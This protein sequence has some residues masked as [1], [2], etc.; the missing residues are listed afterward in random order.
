MN[1]LLHI[2]V[3]YYIYNN[4]LKVL[5]IFEQMDEYLLYYNEY[6][7][8]YGKNN[9][10][11]LMQVGSFF[12]I[13][14]Y[15]ENLEYLDTVANVLGIRRTRK[16]GGNSSNGGNNND[17]Y[18]SSDSDSYDDDDSSSD[19]EKPITTINKGKK[20][21]ATK[22]KSI[23]TKNNGKKHRTIYMSGFMCHKIDNFL[24]KL[25]ECNYTVIEIRQVANKQKLK[26]DTV[27]RYVNKVYTPGTYILNPV[28]KESNYLMYLY[29]EED[30]VR[31]YGNIITSC[32]VSVVD[33]STGETIVYEVISSQHDEKYALD[34]GLRFIHSYAPKEIIVCH[35]GPKIIDSKYYD[36]F[37]LAEKMIQNKSLTKESIITYFELENKNYKYYNTIDK[38]FKCGKY[39]KAYLSKIYKDI[40]G[41]V[42]DHLHLQRKPYALLSLL[43]LMDYVSLRDKQILDKLHKPIIFRS[44]K[45]LLLGNNAV[46]QLNVI[47]NVNVGNNMSNC[48]NTKKIS[49]LFDV[50]N[51]TKTP[52]GQRYLYNLLINPIIN[53]EELQTAYNRIEE[54]RIDKFYLKIEEILKKTIDFER[55]WRKLMLHRIDPYEFLNF[56]KGLTSI[57]KLVTMIHEHGTPNIIKL[58]PDQAVLD[59][60]NDFLINFK[61]DFNLH[62]MK[63]S[64]LATLEKSIFNPDYCIKI[65]CARIVELQTLIDLETGLMDEICSVLAKYLIVDGKKNTFGNAIK[66]KYINK[67]G[68]YLYMTKKKSDMLKNNI[69]ALDTIKI[70][71][72]FSINPKKLRFQ[73]TPNNKNT[74]IFFDELG[75]KSANVDLLKTEL[76]ELVM[77]TIIDAYNRYGET[78]DTTFRQIFKF[79]T[80]IDNL[81]SNAKVSVIYN[82]CKPKI[83]NN[84]N[85]Y[86][87]TTQLRHPIIERIRTDVEYIPHDIALGQRG[88]ETYNNDNDN[89]NNNNN[90][91]NNNNNNDKNNNTDN[92]MN[93]ILIYGLNSSG[94]SSL[95]KA[96]G[97]SIVMAQCGMY[98]P[99]MSFE[100]SPYDSLF[101]RITGNDDIFKGQSSFTLEMTELATI[102]GRTG[103][104]TL[105]IG[106]EVCRGTEHISGTAIVA[107][108]IVELSKTKS[109][110]IFASHL[111]D[112]ATMDE[113]VSLTNVKAVHL[114]VEHDPI[115][116]TLIYDRKI[117]DG[118]GDTIYGF[119][120]AKYIIKNPIFMDLVVKIKNKM[121][122]NYDS[123]LSDKKSKYNSSIFMDHCVICGKDN[124]GT[125]EFNS[126]LDSH[127][128]N[129]QK[130]CKDGFII[131]KPHVQM[132]SEANL[133]VLCKECHHKVHHNELIIRGYNDTI[134]GPVIDYEFI[135]KGKNEIITPNKTNECP[136]SLQPDTTTATIVVTPILP[137][138]PIL[139]P[140]PKP[141]PP[142]K[143][144][145]LL[146]PKLTTPLSTSTDSF[147]SSNGSSSS[148]KSTKTTRSTKST[149]TTKS[150]N[151]NNIVAKKQKT[152]FADHILRRNSKS[153]KT[154]DSNI[155]MYDS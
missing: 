102:L 108:T 147:G 103:P 5:V 150:K 83:H 9:I 6:S 117:K 7:L 64:S 96:I 81:Q 133:I 149:E 111:H 132:N 51:H 41:N 138:K 91:N 137:S 115:K 154:K 122:G 126:N 135:Q 90:D 50:I 56:Y 75:D 143:P 89:N 45:H 48:L 59:N 30:F 84:E 66:M 49:S 76:I 35:I 141:I 131:N 14:A 78:Y 86:I 21:P 55:Y 23:T 114:T 144:S 119:T 24:P 13:Y 136:T 146:K 152:T 73:D 100:Y 129:F 27:E 112:I 40:N 123:L 8:K 12:E 63:H 153:K 36:D 93:G 47:G 151:T 29:I 80:L 37:E 10:V 33:F 52:M 42:I 72:T 110:F 99:A 43:G 16:H 82:Y 26:I 139:P 28:S 77:S 68:H 104:K 128:I 88:A 34:E 69:S 134:N 127:H 39:V 98:V 17:T 11:V 148:S 22:N 31:A 140:K 58:L 38:N 3:N 125:T 92:A 107:A 61:A 19:E 67:V 54:C 62:I 118:P 85:G 121:L 130:D 15:K 20:Q 106:D 4:S 94:K 18:D 113:V 25:L 109:S 95:M 1:L 155:D 101:A 97:L 2:W 65:N 74:K 57:P 60:L 142:P 145:S 71:N 32:G 87:R 46:N 120:V 70:N 124:V 44:N 79:I 105:V 53:I 116:D